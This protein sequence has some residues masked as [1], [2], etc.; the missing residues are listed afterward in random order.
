MIRKIVFLL[1]IFTTSAQS[2]NCQKLQLLANGGLS[3]RIFSIN[4]SISDSYASY[5]EK[6]RPG[7]NYNLEFIWF[8]DDQGIGIKYSNYLNKVSGK[9][10]RMTD[11]VKIDKSETVYIEFYSLQYH[12]RKQSGKS[13][14]IGDFA[15]GLG[16][17][18][19]SSLGK[20]FEEDVEDKGST[21]GLSATLS[22]NYQILKWM[23]F[24]VSSN[25]F[26]ANIKAIT[27]NGFDWPVSE[28][29]THADVGAGLVFSY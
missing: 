10:L 13:R 11:V 6:K 3:Y 19:Y 5:L 1:I 26:I 8:S 24:G 17:V 4:D 9:N 27:R 25:I 23:A 29:L 2:I 7:Y 12:K 16:Y 21:Y 14:F 18:R 15:V 22:L 20:E 28:G